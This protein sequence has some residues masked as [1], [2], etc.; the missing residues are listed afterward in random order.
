VTV[1]TTLTPGEMAV[2][3]AA[4]FTVPRP[5]NAT[6]FA[7]LLASLHVF[8]AC[9]AGGFA[10]GR[11]IADEAELLTLA[12]E[13]GRRRLGLGRQLLSEVEETARRRRA[14]RLFLEVAEDNAAALA[15][16]R[17][18]G[19]A[20]TGRRRGYYRVP[21]GPAVDALILAKELA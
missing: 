3:H 6:E 20:E 9:R 2:L 18:A 1:T 13:P 8:A 10:L 12:V 5:W 14:G 11:V 15:L 17:A 7:D 21:G 19:L 16:Y 4:C